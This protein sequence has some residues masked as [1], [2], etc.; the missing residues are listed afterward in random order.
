MWSASVF[1]LLGALMLVALASA[2]STETALMLFMENLQLPHAASTMLLGGMGVFISLFAVLVSPLIDTLVTM[3]VPLAASSVAL[4][5]RVLLAALTT[6]CIPW[7]PPATTAS[8]AAVIAIQVAL[9]FIMVLDSIFTGQ[10]LTLCLNTL[11]ERTQGPLAPTNT[12]DAVVA[13]VFGIS[14]ALG[15]A[16]VL[17]ATLGYD[18]LRSYATTPGTANAM[19][20]WLG[21]AANLLLLAVMTVTV[22]IAADSPLQ[23]YSLLRVLQPATRETQTFWERLLEQV[24]SPSLWRF[25]AMCLFLL[26]TSSIFRHL[27]QTLPP[28]MQRSFGKRVHF[29]AVQAIN[30]AVVIFL[31]PYLQFAT[32]RWQ[33][34]WVITLGSVVSSASLLPVVIGA[35]RRAATDAAPVT[36]LDYLPYALFVLIFSVG[37]ALWSARFKAFALKVAPVNNKAFYMA[38]STIPQ[39]G[40]RVFAA[41][42][43][44]WMVQQYCPAD[45]PPCNP[46]PL[47]AT[48]LGFS[49][50]TPIVLTLFV[51]WLNPQRPPPTLTPVPD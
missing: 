30:P 19:A 45:A 35:S 23:E 11:V 25:A 13:R 41:W 3:W 49:L 38:L 48:V 18:A 26:G 31:A 9:L 17:V 40:V 39:L 4:G 50:L 34:Y 33:G 44:A 1:L 42:H 10:V 32:A 27:D 2:L 12:G 8:V 24:R 28:V 47:W 20:Q 21:V 29:A 6:Y 36:F 22:V 5:L 16:A 15:N 46:R 51:R 37:E 7:L 43:S 14:Y